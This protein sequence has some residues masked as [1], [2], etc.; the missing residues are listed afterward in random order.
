MEVNHSADAWIVKLDGGGNMEWQKS[1]GGTSSDYATCI[2]Q[3]SDEGYILL[4][5]VLLPVMQM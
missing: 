5:V 1:R 3:T 2:Q 4:R